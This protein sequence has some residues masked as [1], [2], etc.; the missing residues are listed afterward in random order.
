MK[1]GSN[2]KILCIILFAYLREIRK[3]LFHCSRLKDTRIM[4][5]CLRHV[6]TIVR[7]QSFFADFVSVRS[8]EKWYK[9]K[10]T[11][12]LFMA[13]SMVQVSSKLQ[14]CVTFHL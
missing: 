9:E 10:L 3:S 7:N 1:K 12:P 11:Q 6:E 14:L 13:Y 4:T 5:L 2:G 8:E